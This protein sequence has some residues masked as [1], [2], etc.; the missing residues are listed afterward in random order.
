MFR[1]V[2][3]SYFSEQPFKNNYLC[4]RYLGPSEYTQDSFTYFV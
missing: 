3:Q 2:Y 1:Q 4:D